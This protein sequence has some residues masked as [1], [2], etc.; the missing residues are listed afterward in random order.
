MQPP[1]TGHSNRALVLAADGSDTFVRGVAVTTHSALTRLS[2]DCNADVYLLD[3][4][5]S[6]DSRARLARVLD[7][8]LAGR[9]LHWVPVDRSRFA[10]LP[11]VPELPAIVY[12]RL[13]IPELLPETVERVVYLDGDTLVRHD[14]SP[15]F[16]LPLDGALTAAVRDYM[17]DRTDHVWSGIRGPEADRPY[18]N[19]GVLVMDVPGWRRERLGERAVEYVKSE[20]A[21]RWQDQDAINAVIGDWHELEPGWNVQ[22][23]SLRRPDLTYFARDADGGRGAIERL[24][25]TGA[26]L[27]FAGAAKPWNPRASVACGHS[28]IIH[29]IRAG[30]YDDHEAAG[31]LSSWLTRHA[32]AG[33]GAY[34][35][36][37][38]RRARAAA[39]GA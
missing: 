39:P 36:K 1:A 16:E 4:G 21:L 32:A 2:S 26:V 15:L 27:H 13:L 7:S 30:W 35:R 20:G 9:R 23:G 6:Q 17:I 8:A 24:T 37:L 14:L 34:G 25:A 18:L 33:I 11:V 22:L 38:I 29:L 31:W 19:A 10:H 5:I 12:S 28:W 3:N